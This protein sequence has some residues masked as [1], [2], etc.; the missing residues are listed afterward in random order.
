MV[1][2]E[3][4][5]LSRGI[6]YLGS[7][8][9][10]LRDLSGAPTL[11]YELLQNADDAPGANEIRF[12]V[13][14]RELV[15]WNNGSFTDC[16]RQDLEPDECPWFVADEGSRRC[17][18]HS[19]R[20]VSSGDKAR[21]R[22]L[23]GAFGIGFTAVYQVTD[24]PELI[25]TGRHWT[26]DETLPEGQRISECRSCAVCNG[27]TGTRFVLPWATDP[28]ST[29]RIKAKL[30]PI[31]AAAIGRI[32]DALLD[33]VP[34]AMLF[35]KKIRSVEINGSSA[36]LAKFERV[37]DGADIL[38]ANGPTTH[39]WRILRGDFDREAEALRA[40]YP[41]MQEKL[42]G[43]AIAVARDQDSPGRLCAYLPTEQVIEMPFHVNADFFP[44]SDRKR[45]ITEGYQGEWNRTAVSAAAR[46]LTQHIV[47]LRDICGHRRIWSLISAAHQLSTRDV[48]RLAGLGL[49]A[50]WKELDGR[51][52]TLPI[53]WTV[54]GRWATPSGAFIVRDG[55]EVGAAEVLAELGPV[56]AH[57]DL[58]P[59]CLSLPRYGGLTQFTLI[60]LVEAL[61]KSGLTARHEVSDLPD[62]LRDAP[63]R[64]AVLSEL[65]RLLARS[66]DQ[67]KSVRY[68]LDSIAIAP[69]LDGA[70]WPWKQC[71]AADIA[72]RALFDHSDCPMGFI[73]ESVLPE[74]S[75]HLRELVQ[76]FGMEQGVEC[77]EARPQLAERM[78]AG[79]I[80]SEKL[81]EWLSAHRGE[82]EREPILSE[83]LAVLPIYPT[84]RS[85]KP[86][87]ELVLPG[88][89]RDELQ[90]S[91][92]V[93]IGRAGD[94]L[95]LLRA[96][97]CS[98]LTL[99]DYV[100]RFVPRSEHL[101]Q[102]DPE[103]WRQ[104][105]FLLAGR[106]GDIEGDEAARQV[107]KHVAIVIIDE[108]FAKPEDA[109]FGGESVERVLGSYTQ[110]VLP[111]GHEVAV[112]AFYEWVG[113]AR[114]PKPQDIMRRVANLASGPLT[115]EARGAVARIVE[116]LG[117]RWKI[118]P[119]PPFG[120]L[121]R[122]KSL[123]WLPARSDTS[124]WYRPNEL[125]AVFSEYLFATQAR[126]LGLPM[127]VQQGANDYLLALGVGAGPTTAQVV[128]HLLTCAGAKTNMNVEV[129]T[130]L[131]QHASETEVARLRDEKSILLPDGQWVKPSWVYWGDQPFGRFRATLG[132]DFHRFRPLLARLGVREHPNH[133]DARDVLL[134]MSHELAAMNTPVDS[135][136][137]RLVY[138]SCWRL[139]AGALNSQTV[140]PSF[141]TDFREHKVIAD[142]EWLLSYPNWILFDDV[143]GLADRFPAALKKQ[144]IRRPE[145]YWPAMR[146]AGVKD[147]SHAMV[148]QIL[149]L[150]DHQDHQALQAL[151]EA[152]TRQLGR[153]LDAVD[154]QWPV[155]LP[156][157]L[158]G[159]RLVSASKLVVQFVLSD[160][161]LVSPPAALLS[162]Y[163]AGTDS[164]FTRADVPI[165]EL[166]VAREVARALAPDVA[167]GTLAPSLGLVLAAGSPEEADRR[168]DAAGVPRLAEGVAGEAEAQVVSSFGGERGAAQETFTASLGE[169]SEPRS[170]TPAGPGAGSEGSP[171]DDRGHAS[172]GRLRSYVLTGGEISNGRGGAG[173]E[174]EISEIDR[175]GVDRVVT[176]EL[177]AGR[178]PRKMEHHNPGY[179]VE[180]SGADGQVLRY[181][182][183]KSLA[184]DWTEFGVSVTPRQMDEARGRRELFWL[185]VVERAQSE[186]FAV[187]PIQD[188]WTKV[189]QFMFDDPWKLVASRASAAEESDEPTGDD[190]AAAPAQ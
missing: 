48:P 56:F 68:R 27:E 141:F 150:G 124:R 125:Y 189:D 152:R 145:A 146:A 8:S 190:A 75:A 25:S 50:F 61:E 174:D 62:V 113:V 130:F 4:K 38:I 168:L 37:D 93:D 175:A 181:I 115:D 18:F 116:Y 80:A 81:L 163:D 166:E 40:R 57:P 15:V 60:N 19:F 89:F 188:P 182:E 171:G 138:M 22:N 72:S 49:E 64:A 158:G 139:L 94:A 177:A 176:F 24:R 32:R 149:E 151:L 134:D 92:V 88:G 90:L 12:D 187:H 148:S 59:F 165:A 36:T 170:D 67:R 126:F 117:A 101:A 3:P 85:H 107:L 137:D 186:D 104:L 143:P 69:G 153:V 180:S 106:L 121:D 70:V 118:Q 84:Q 41:T 86:I 110:A 11:V 136:D 95:P 154:P 10:I 123:A 14:D 140:E 122:L 51:I 52:D 78:D 111:A 30:P 76:Q 33:T 159:L 6:D 109:Y 98:E 120:D 74:D 157:R 97:G 129:Y 161:K 127:L 9:R 128:A 1:G 178:N 29:F 63:A 103:R 44:T 53:L 82:L 77:L 100:T 160:F 17:D 91:D 105:I 66:A 185:Y 65:E 83:R 108:G 16:G 55:D 42:T 39:A 7:I 112:R 20:N 169:T 164:L 147:L 114:D 102:S 142:G 35:L 184:G 155:T 172:K 54:E 119:R 173:R 96:L 167:P 5:T 21:D 26:I 132:D 162:L 135:D 133:V 99:G 28:R 79:E 34:T 46:V 2:Q 31:D 71:F 23:T 58:R 183:V 87:A 144:L 45:L 13:T 156:L 179:D 131:N 73:D 43:I 47:E